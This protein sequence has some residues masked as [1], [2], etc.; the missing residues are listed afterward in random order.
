V[1]ARRRQPVS[2]P[3]HAG[4]FAGRFDRAGLRWPLRIFVGVAIASALG[5]A[6]LGAGARPWLFMGLA[7]AGAF[8]VWSVW[9]ETRGRA[10]TIGRLRARWLALPD[11]I[12]NGADL[13]F[14]E[15]GQPLIARL[16][17]GASG[18]TVTILTPLRE[19][20]AAF[21][22]ASQ[23]LP[24]PGFDG[25][26]PPIGGPPLSPLPGLQSMLHDELRIEGNEPA[27]LERWLDQTLVSALLSAARDHAD[28]FRGL[29]FD[30]RF[31]AVHWVGELA[32]DPL[33]VRALSAPLWRPFVPR[34]PPPRP[35]LLN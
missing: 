25:A 14:S 33:T 10:A 6:F 4:F 21:R 11:V 24:R 26:D 9:D 30:G 18:H 7:A 13:H 12:D 20:T 8:L 2:A 19:T 3:W 16:A 15:D 22:I 23:A 31:L 34:L 5:L 1:A 27:Q 32:A 35:E 29:T 17:T 28:S